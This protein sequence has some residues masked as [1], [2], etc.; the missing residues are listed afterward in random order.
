[1]HALAGGGRVVERLGPDDDDIQFRGTFSGPSAEARARAFDTLRLSGDI[2]WLTWESFRRQ[3]IV[4]SFTADYHSPWW[5][6]Y[7]IVCVTV[8]QTRIASSDDTS[9]AAII[10][11]DLNSAVSIAAGSGISLVS[12][13]AA[14]SNRNALTAGT[15]DQ[16]QV[17]AEVGS[18][19]REINGQ[20][21][22][23]STALMASIP[24]GGARGDLA[25][26]YVSRVNTANSLAAACNVR[27]YVGR[28]GVN[29][30][31]LGI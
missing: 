31:G 20:M 5:I 16:T 25:Q 1:V 12:L 19:L 11:A 3:I 21:D 2:V 7:Q 17:I 13:Q 29:V 26:S 4:K 24:P 14:L 23:Q 15:G 27:S 22:R 10:S 9:L 6:P 8:C 18:T 28:I 30:M